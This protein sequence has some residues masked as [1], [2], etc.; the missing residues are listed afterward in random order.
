MKVSAKIKQ[1]SMRDYSILEIRKDSNKNMSFPN[2]SLT[3]EKDIAEYIVVLLCKDRVEQELAVRKAKGIIDSEYEAL[4]G[5][6]REDLFD[7]LT[8]GYSGCGNL[9]RE[10]SDKLWEDHLDPL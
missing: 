5:M 8:S 6:C 7:Y 9:V 4:L 10:D 2:V 1:T 3:M